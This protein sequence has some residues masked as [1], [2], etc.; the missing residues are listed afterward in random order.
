MKDNRRNPD[1]LDMQ[2]RFIK[3]G[4]AVAIIVPIA[5]LVAIYFHFR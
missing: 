2:A 1:V 5:L 3:F 4:T